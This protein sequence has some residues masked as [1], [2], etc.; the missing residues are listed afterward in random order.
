MT[1]NELKSYV[2]R[3]LGD[4]VRVLL[5]SY[6]WK[7][8]FGAV[9]DKVEEKV[10]KDDLKTVN[11]E[12]IL[13]E[14]DLKI[15]V[16]SVESVEELNA[17]DA[18]VGDMA[19][20]GKEA[21]NVVSVGDLPTT[22]WENF[23]E[24]WDKLTRINKI[25][26]GEAINDG[27]YVQVLLSKKGESPLHDAIQILSQEGWIYLA[28]ALRTSES[29]SSAIGISIDKANQLLRDGDYRLYFYNASNGGGAE[30]VDRVVKLIIDS[31]SA[32]AYIKSNS[33]DKLAK[34]YI[35]PSEEELN[36]LDV[37]NGTIA[38]VVSDGCTKISSLKEPT[39]FD[40]AIKIK[41]VAISAPANVA[42]GA[43]A[44]FSSKDGDVIS[45]YY[46]DN[47]ITY[48]TFFSNN[49]ANG[50]IYDNGSFVTGSID[51]INGYLSQKDFAY[52]GYTVQNDSYTKEEALSQID[53]WL[54][55]YT[56]SFSNA[57]IKSDTWKR[58]LKEGDA[59]GGAIEQRELYFKGDDTFV[60]NVEGEL[61]QEQ[62]DYNLETVELYKKGEVTLVLNMELPH[63]NLEV[64]CYPTNYVE[65]NGA[66]I[67]CCELN[68]IYA[69]GFVVVVVSPTGDTEF[70]FEG[71]QS[72][73][74]DSSLSTTSTN[75]IQNKV[76]T[77]ALNEKA[78][79]AYVDEK[80]ANAGGGGSVT[81]D[82]ELSETSENPIANKAVYEGFVA[83]EQEVLRLHEVQ[84]Q[85]TYELSVD[86]NN[87]IVKKADTTYV[88]EKV[89]AIVVPTKVSQLTNDSNF[90]T[91]TQLAAK[92]D[93]IN[94]LATIRSNASLGATAIQSVKTINGQSIV[95]SGNVV[96]SVDT[97]N[98]ATKE[99]VANLTN[100]ILDNEE[101]VAS[102][103]NDLNVR[104]NE[105]SENVSGEAATKVEL[106]DA[107]DTINQTIDANDARYAEEFTSLDTQIKQLAANVQGEA[108][109]KT[110]FE[111]T[112]SNL[113]N[114]IL[115][116]EEV[117]ASAINDLNARIAAL[118]EM[119]TT[120]QNN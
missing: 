15:G 37:P 14:G 45:L 95:G 108:V 50:T 8:A 10:E 97:S 48:T 100:D 58:L 72:I 34:E 70:Y 66:T 84:G 40:D 30:A 68:V 5:P 60:G 61:T 19:T 12:S 89:G 101:V 69:Q 28:R 11:G 24:E 57:Y 17:L 83:I 65:S 43:T 25:E 41:K 113:N 109:T 26:K 51:V 32:D 1:T 119:I 99:E 33:W 102:A 56:T 38:Q 111:S 74:V 53:S 116:N 3:I 42:L 27:S 76:V 52:A 94:D 120:L 62:L 71:K 106:N 75:A 87:K 46:S 117:V 88:D 118:E 104:I 39:S 4:S 64:S 20:V 77:A 107:V 93:T 54:S 44:L 86:L 103:I 6:W 105:L 82:T 92:Q 18:E 73:T 22:T 114:E 36:R 80:V 91:T 9:I 112:L 110:E 78:S 63:A 79:I 2:D 29:S 81:V 21:L 67:I 59:T 55:V 47:K 16:K 96:I 98:L 90:A 31:S 7:R 49:L 23:S 115:D 85:L 13:G 35:V